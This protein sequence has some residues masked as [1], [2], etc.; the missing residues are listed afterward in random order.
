MGIGDWGLGIG[1]LGIGDWGLS[2]IPNHQSPLPIYL[3]QLSHLLK[4]NSLLLN[5]FLM[6][7]INYQ[8]NKYKLIFQ[9]QQ[10]FLNFTNIFTFNINNS[11]VNANIFIRILSMIIICVIISEF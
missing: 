1:G 6:K 7:S 9:N 3:L 2:Q 5:S 4:Y 11:F 10:I 8:E